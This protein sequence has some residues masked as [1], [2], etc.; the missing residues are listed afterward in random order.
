MVSSGASVSPRL[1]LKRDM[2]GASAYET[3]A[4]MHANQKLTANETDTIA[5][6]CLRL[7][8]QRSGHDIEIG[9]TNQEG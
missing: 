1:W 4:P 2:A 3:A 9:H 7:R 6:T 8:I 5:E